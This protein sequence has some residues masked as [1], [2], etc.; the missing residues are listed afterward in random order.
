MSTLCLVLRQEQDERGRPGWSLQVQDAALEARSRWLDWDTI[1]CLNVQRIGEGVQRPMD[2]G[3]WKESQPAP[4]KEYQQRYKLVNDCLPKGRQRILYAI[5]VNRRLEEWQ[6]PSAHIIDIVGQ[7][8]VCSQLGLTKAIE[9]AFVVEHV[10]HMHWN[11]ICKADKLANKG[12]V[13]PWRWTPGVTKAVSA[14]SGLW[15]ED[16]IL[17][18]FYRCKL[19]SGLIQARRDTQRW[20]DNVKLQLQHLAAA[21]P[22]GTSQVAIQQPVAVTPAT[23]DAERLQKRSCKQGSWREEDA[24]KVSQQL[25]GTREQLVFL[26][27]NVGIGARGGWGAKA[28]LQACRK[29]VESPNSSKPTD[30]LPGKVVTVDAQ[31]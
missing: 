1:P 13:S 31:L 27:G 4:G 2:L 22:V 30:R 29:V 11:R 25:W 12:P 6:D 10:I 14:A 17:D 18:S 5:N 20:N 28:V 15:V 26:F 21:A 16:G 19:T 3:S 8:L 24:A 23:W 9:A 7:A